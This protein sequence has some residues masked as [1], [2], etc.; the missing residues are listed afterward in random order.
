MLKPE[1]WGFTNPVV[2]PLYGKPPLV[3]KDMRVQLVVYETDIENIERVVPEPLE[4]RTNKVITWVSEFEL[5]TTQGAFS[6]MAIYVQVSYDGLDGDYEPFLYVS[7]PLP[8]TA[9]RE[10]WGYQKKMAE[11]GISYEQEATIG[12]V[13]RL[14]HDILKAIVVPEYNAV[15][16]EVPWSP[17]GVFSLKYI[18]SAEEGGTPVRE[19]V[20]TEG[21]FT[22]QE[23]RFFGGRASVNYER[24]E[25]DPTYL[26]EPNKI[27]GGFFGQ[28]D[29]YLPLG[30]VVHGYRS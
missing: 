17:D 18:P 15:M 22:A 8:L 26:L 16:D 7:T 4:V 13:T 5:G 25:I 6:E 2:S 30:K 12:K 28:G 11:I 3:W 1:D 14:D 10:I 20:L 19:L 23:G 9:G 29:L 24:S 21:K 27:L